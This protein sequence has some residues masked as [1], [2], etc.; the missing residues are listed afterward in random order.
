M[1]RIC[2]DEAT[3]LVSDLVALPTV[4]PMGRPYSGALPVER[5]VVEYLERL[6]APYGVKTERQSCSPIHDVA[7]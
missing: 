7:A 1:K 4:N 6:L 2:D 5:P 3:R